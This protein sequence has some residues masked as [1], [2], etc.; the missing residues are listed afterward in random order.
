MFR[1]LL[2]SFVLNRGFLFRYS[3]HGFEVRFLL[4]QIRGWSYTGG[5]TVG[6]LIVHS[7]QVILERI[8]ALRL[9]HYFPSFRKECGADVS[10][11]PATP[12][13]Y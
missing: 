11:C 2:Y 3:Q 7:L 12:S 5:L 6:D 8:A 4:Q 13:S 1:E 10:A 9:C